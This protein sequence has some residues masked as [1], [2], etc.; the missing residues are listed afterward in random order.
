MVAVAIL[1]VAKA[2]RIAGERVELVVGSARR[3]AAGMALSLTEMVHLV[4]GDVACSFSFSIAPGGEQYSPGILMFPTKQA[5]NFWG[6]WRLLM[7]REI[8]V[9]VS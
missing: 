5:T 1:V 6:L 7:S 9:F 3:A 2:E 4:V 8:L